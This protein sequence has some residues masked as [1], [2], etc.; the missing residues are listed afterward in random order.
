M[1]CCEILN[2]GIHV[3]IALACT[4]Y[5]NIVLDQVHPFIE[6]IYHDGG[7]LIQQDNALCH[8]VKMV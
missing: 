4:T 8:I 1:F 5:L 2:S 3:D 7:D 6:T